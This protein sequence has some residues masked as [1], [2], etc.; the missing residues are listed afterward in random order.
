M[1]L[2]RHARLQQPRRVGDFFVTERIELRGG[3]IGGW[4]AGQ[5]DG[6]RRGGVLRGGRRPGSAAIRQ[7]A[8]GRRRLA[9]EATWIATYQ[10]ILEARLDRLGRFLSK[11]GA[12]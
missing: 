5:I 2:D 9:E 7:C 6:P 12:Q 8:L 10:A 3:D 1:Q 11:G 4:Q